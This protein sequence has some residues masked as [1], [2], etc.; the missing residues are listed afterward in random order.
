MTVDLAFPFVRLGNVPSRSYN[1]I[2]IIKIIKNKMKPNK[3]KYSLQGTTVIFGSIVPQ[4]LLVSCVVLI[5]AALVF[6]TLIKHA[7]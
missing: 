1:A 5:Q 6:I 4:L 2:S 3:I 7:K